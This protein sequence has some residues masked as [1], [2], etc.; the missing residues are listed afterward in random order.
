MYFRGIHSYYIAYCFETE[1]EHGFG[2]MILHNKSKLD[3]RTSEDIKVVEEYIKDKS[4]EIKNTELKNIIIM[5]WREL[6][7]E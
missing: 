5:D 7:N 1:N 3:I 2:K 4:K 6:K